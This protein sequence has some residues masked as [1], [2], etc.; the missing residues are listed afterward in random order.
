LGK[1]NDD[2]LADYAERKGMQK[3]DAEKWLRQNLD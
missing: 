2:Q 1:I 3:E